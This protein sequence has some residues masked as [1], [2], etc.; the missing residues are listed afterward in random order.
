MLRRWAYLRLQGTI[1]VDI[2]L[3]M[4][5]GSQLRFTA[6]AS[7]PLEAPSAFLDHTRLYVS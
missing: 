3:L 2:A 4:G 7:V 6:P 5:I 1:V